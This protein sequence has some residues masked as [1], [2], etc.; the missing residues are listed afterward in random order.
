MD[1]RRVICNVLFVSLLFS[2][3]S[4]SLCLE[5]EY[6]IETENE[7]ISVPICAWDHD[8]ATG[9]K[10]QTLAGPVFNNVYP[11]AGILMGFLA[12]RFNRKIMLGFSL[13]FWS[14]ATGVT[15]FAQSYWM[16]VVFRMLLAIG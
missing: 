4:Q 11:L 3:H 7:T 16:L 14:V 10:Y 13:L 9:I 6:D 12:D 15:G 5:Y 1:S 2:K 8:G